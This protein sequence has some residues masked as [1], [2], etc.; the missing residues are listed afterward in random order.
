MRT[1]LDLKVGTWNG[2]PATAYEIAVNYAR[3][4]DKEKSLEWLEKCYE[5][6]DGANLP[7]MNVDPAFAKIRNDPR[8]QD[9]ARRIGVL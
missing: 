2:D 1:V 6:H 3:L 4:G 8:F 9:L 5:L 7:V